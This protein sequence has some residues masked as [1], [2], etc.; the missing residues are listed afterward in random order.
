MEYKMSSDASN[1]GED[2]KM[3]TPP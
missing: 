1:K 3:A 2:L